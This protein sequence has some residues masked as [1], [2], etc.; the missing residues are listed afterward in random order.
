MTSQPAKTRERAFQNMM[1]KII[2]DLWKEQLCNVACIPA[3]QPFGR[4]ISYIQIAREDIQRL[5]LFNPPQYLRTSHNQ[6]PFLRLRTQATT[7]IPSHLHLH[8]IH[9]YTPYAERY[10]PSCLPLQIPSN[11]NET[12]TLFH[13][14]YFSPLAQP[15]IQSL[16]LN[17]R[18]FDLW[19]WA[20][21]IDPQKVS[22]LLGCIPPKLDRQHEKTWVVLT[23]ATCTQL[24]YSIQSHYHLALL[25]PPLPLPLLLLSS[26]SLF[27]QMIFTVKY[28]IVHLTNIKCSSVAF[29]TQDGIWTVSLHPSPPSQLGLGNAPYVPLA[30]P[31]SRQQHNTFASP[32]SFSNVT[33]TNIKKRNFFFFARTITLHIS[34]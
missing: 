2:S 5:D 3:R 11:G 12:R 25:C 18:P 22:M 24:I 19:A 9:T 23:S 33:P 13:C 4:K 34:T 21:Y 15:A 10:C 14:P 16:M 32:P 29:V 8:N 7:Y 30:T 20:T 6:L 26:P 17:L 28:V 1:R 31:Y 27:L